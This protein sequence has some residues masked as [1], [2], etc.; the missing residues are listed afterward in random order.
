MSEIGI[1]EIFEICGASIY[2][3]DKSAVVGRKFNISIDSRSIK[4][5]DVYWA[6]PGERF[7]GH[8]FVQDALQKKAA[9]CVVQE[10]RLKKREKPAYPCAAIPDSITGLQE[11]GRI[12]RSLFDI[13]VLALTGS[14]G[15]T[16]TKE[17]TAHILG[18]R[19]NVHKTSGNFNNHI[20]CPLTLLELNT[21]HQAAVIELGTNHPGEISVLT[22]TALPNHALITNAAVHI[23]NFS[24]QMKPLPVKN[25]ICSWRWKTAGLFT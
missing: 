24:R 1:N 10:N 23:L 2:N 15:K 3:I 17:M 13:P 9:F 21:A 8:E 11:L 19:L 20:G 18:S 14:N 4:K 25:A 12:H 7:D 6:V 22:R 5:G 16:T